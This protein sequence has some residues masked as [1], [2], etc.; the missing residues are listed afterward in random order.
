MPSFD[1][2]WQLA[3]PMLRSF[4]R[5]L[6]KNVDDAEDLLV[7]VR[8]SA[9][10][11]FD[12]FLSNANFRTWAF[13]IMRNRHFDRI[14]MARSRISA[15][16]YDNHADSS[17]GS[18][19]EMV[20]LIADPVRPFDEMFAGREIAGSV[21]EIVGDSRV[22]LIKAIV[23][24]DTYPDM[25]ADLGIPQGTIKS[26]LNRLRKFFRLDGDTIIY[27]GPTIAKIAPA[28]PSFQMGLSIS[29]LAQMEATGC[30]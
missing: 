11:A 1:G 3:E 6:T 28:P 25:A 17:D 13:K 15:V 14:K 26:R 4:A 22:E 21:I 27:N 2:E 29:Q 30:L 16:S 10:K 9:W 5:R 24:G 12:S 18:I 19:L 20:G 23:N 7:E 8:V